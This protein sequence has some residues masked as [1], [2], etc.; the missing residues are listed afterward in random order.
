MHAYLA[1]HQTGM[2]WSEVDSLIKIASRYYAV[3]KGFY[4]A[5]LTTFA[6]LPLLHYLQAEQQLNEVV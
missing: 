6:A 1:A 4:H 5:M 2:M 3:V